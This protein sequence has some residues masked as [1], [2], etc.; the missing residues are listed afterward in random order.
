M[1]IIVSVKLNDGIVMAADS[2]VSFAIGQIY[3]NA[4]KIVNL[5]KGLPIGVMT[6]GAGGIGNASVATLLKDLRQRLTGEDDAHT[7][8]KIDVNDYTMESVTSR[9]HEFFDE[10]VKEADKN[11]I[12][13]RVCGYSSARPLAE[14]WQIA[15]FEDETPTELFC[16]QREDSF[17]CRWNGENEALDRLILGI[18]TVP[19]DGAKALGLTTE[20]TAETLRKV[21]PHTYESLILNAAPIQDAIDLARFMVETTKGFIRFSITRQKTVG[22]PIEIAA[23]T[24]HEGFKWVQRKHFFSS[25]FNKPL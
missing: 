25:E 3:E 15:F 19:E 6:C 17:G 13:M 20:Q 16:V 2:A 10:K 11:F 9:V 4:N 1:S 8:W 12:L 22:G 23:I 7:D 24:K 14:V 5:V 18:G 21:Y